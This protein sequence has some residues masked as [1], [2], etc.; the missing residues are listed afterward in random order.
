MSSINS[1]LYNVLEEHF[2][3]IKKY[4]VAALENIR[5]KRYF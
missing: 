3:I 2:A 4:A 1:L 5:T